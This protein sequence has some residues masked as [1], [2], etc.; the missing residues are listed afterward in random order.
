MKQGTPSQYISPTNDVG[1]V[2]PDVQLKLEQFEPIQRDTL[3]YELRH[4]R[5]TTSTSI[6]EDERRTPAKHRD[7]L[8]RGDADGHAYLA[9]VSAA[10]EHLDGIDGDEPPVLVGPAWF[11]QEIVRGALSTHIEKLHGVMDDWA[12]DE[13]ESR[14]ELQR[15]LYLVRLWT[16]SLLAAYEP[17][18]P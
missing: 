4:W 5:E 8:G 2:E 15:T 12:S 6:A 18:L 9:I 10:L 3:D 7:S 1:V 17:P 14:V 16:R 11:V 13:S